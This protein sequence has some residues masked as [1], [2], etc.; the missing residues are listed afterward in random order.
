MNPAKPNFRKAFEHPVNKPVI[1]ALRRIRH[2]ISPLPLHRQESRSSDFSAPEADFLGAVSGS[3]WDFYNG[4][5][6]K[7]SISMDSIVNLARLQ[8]LFAYPSSLEDADLR[9]TLVCISA[10]NIPLH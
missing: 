10:C 1:E 8:N 2:I 6:F 7:E 3:A 4:I 5:P 9:D